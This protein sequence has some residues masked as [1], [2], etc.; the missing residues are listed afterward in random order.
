MAVNLPLLVLRLSNGIVRSHSISYIAC[1]CAFCCAIGVAAY[2][3][4]MKPVAAGSVPDHTLFV[5]A[6]C[7]APPECPCA[8]C[9]LVAGAST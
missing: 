1:A 4:P 6:T 8:G 2:C 5:Y 3:F 9:A 7:T